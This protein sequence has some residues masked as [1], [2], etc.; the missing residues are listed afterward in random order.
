MYVVTTYDKRGSIVSYLYD[1]EGKVDFYIP[2]S[3]WRS[4]GMGW[5]KYNKEGEV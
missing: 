5:M 3:D 4:T 1:D 2:I